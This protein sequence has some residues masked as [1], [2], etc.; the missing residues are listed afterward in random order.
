MSVSPHRV[1]RDL[2]VEERRTAVLRVAVECMASSG[3]D[4]L[5]LRDVASAAGV[6]IG[7]LQHY[8]ETRDDL[9]EEAFRQASEDLLAEW[10]A[11]VA[12]DM[13]PWERLE[14]LVV[15]L[16]RRP[17]LRAHCLVW[18]Q[19]AA[20]AGRHAAMRRGFHAIYD[21]WYRLVSSAVVDGV[22]AGIFHPLLPVED[23]VELLLNQIDGCEL[24]IASG[25]ESLDGERMASLTLSLA[26]TLLGHSPA[27]GGAGSG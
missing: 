11:A 12:T 3:F 17:D 22:D 21:K 9:V 26:A 14:A 5:R 10:A 1:G 23:V 16:A 15:Q 13:R 19:F 20:A 6:S 8:F 4:N 25:D 7:L 2:T 18:V 27:V 24:T